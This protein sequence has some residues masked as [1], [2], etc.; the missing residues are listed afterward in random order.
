MRKSYRF[1]A[2][3]LMAVLF[4]IAANAQTVTVSGT[5]KSGST[6]EGGVAV[7]VAVAETV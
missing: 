2:A 7:T 6:K 3:W 4:S 1:L 5:V